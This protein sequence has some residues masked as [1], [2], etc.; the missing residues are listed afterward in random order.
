MTQVDG[1]VLVIYNMGF[2]NH[3]VGELFE[4]VNDG[5]Y[6]VV[7]FYR[8]GPNATIQVDQLPVQAKFPTGV[9]IIIIVAVVVVPLAFLLV[10]V[11]FVFRVFF[12]FHLFFSYFLSYCISLK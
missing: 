5:Q 10:L 1:S 12:W 3:P 2:M 7:R 11:L 4:K 9:S 6:H 8:D